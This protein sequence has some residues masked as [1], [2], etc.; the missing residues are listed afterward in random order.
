MGAG[1]KEHVAGEQES[2][3]TGGRAMGSGAGREGK[4]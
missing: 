3:A 4:G 1:N 2:G